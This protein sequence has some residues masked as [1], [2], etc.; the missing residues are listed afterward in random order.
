MFYMIFRCENHEEKKGYSTNL[1]FTNHKFVDKM[2]Q[3]TG[4]FFHSLQ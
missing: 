2:E 1:I 4:V 3:F